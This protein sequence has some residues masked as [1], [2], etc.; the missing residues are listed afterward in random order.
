MENEDNIF[1][2]IT[3]LAESRA[4][5]VDKLAK[6]AFNANGKDTNGNQ[7]WWAY[8]KIELN[9]IDSLIIKLTEKIK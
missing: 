5:L 7:T 8:C 3:K 1:T 2:T 4:L 6:S 9:V